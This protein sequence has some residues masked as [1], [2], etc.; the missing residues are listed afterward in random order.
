M[1]ASLT[2]SRARDLEGFLGELEI[3]VRFPKRYSAAL[4]AAVAGHLE[5]LDFRFGEFE[6]DPRQLCGSERH[7]KQGAAL[8]AISNARY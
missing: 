2:A 8:C 7:Q 1:G 5:I 3:F 4:G 6:I